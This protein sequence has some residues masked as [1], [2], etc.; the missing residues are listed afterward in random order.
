MKIID[1]FANGKLYA[2]QYDGEDNHALDIVLE[3]WNEPEYLYEFLKANLKDIPQQKNI[4]QI[5]NEIITNSEEIE[6][7]LEEIAESED[8]FFEEFFKALDNNEYKVLEL[9]RQKGRKNYLRI[10]AIRIDENCFVITGGAIKFTHLM[11]DRPHTL[12]ELHKIEM[13]KNYLK[14]NGVYDLES[15]YEFLNQDL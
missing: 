10:Y 3:Q 5:Q 7:L 12:K 11:K 1:I 8:Q 15:F 14:E 13:C 2:F 4:I 6:D 9:S